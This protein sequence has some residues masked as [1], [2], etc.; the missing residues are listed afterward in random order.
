[1][2]KLLVL[3][4]LGLLL[5]LTAAGESVTP[6]LTLR[7]IREISAVRNLVSAIDL[8]INFPTGS[9]AIPGDQL[10]NL[11][12]M[13]ILI[14]DA[15]ADNPGEVFLI[16]GHTDAVGSEPYNLALSDRR[17]ESVALALTGNFDIP[18]ENLIVQGYGESYLKVPTLV[19]EAENRRATIRRITPLLGEEFASLEF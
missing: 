13:G 1:M 14:E 3:M 9:A 5:P 19:S 10:S 8:E 7:Q 15:L 11:V 2:N 12:E 18:P 4:V 17:A 16:E 6:F